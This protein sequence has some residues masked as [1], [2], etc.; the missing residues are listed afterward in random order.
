MR[1]PERFGDAWIIIEDDAALRPHPAQALGKGQPF[2]QPPI[3][4]DGGVAHPQIAGGMHPRIPIAAAPD[5]GLQALEA[6]RLDGR[7]D[8]V[9]HHAG[10]AGAVRGCHPQGQQAAHR[11]ADHHEAIHPGRIQHQRQIAQIGERHIGERIARPARFAAAAQIGRDQAP[12]GSQRFGE[13]GKIGAVAGEA[14]QAQQRRATGRNARIMM[15]VPAQ[16]HAIARER[17]AFLPAGRRFGP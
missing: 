3:G 1:Q 14:G 4:M 15:F 2:V 9:Q 11:G 6:R 13:R 16:P 5:I 8:I 17:I 7:A 12:I 10:H